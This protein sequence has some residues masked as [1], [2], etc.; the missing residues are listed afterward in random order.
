MKTLFFSLLMIGSF[1]IIQAQDISGVW[2][3]ETDEETAV[4]DRSGNFLIHWAAKGLNAAGSYSFDG[5]TLNCSFSD[6]STQTYSISQLVGGQGFLMTDTESGQTWWYAYQGEAN[7]I[8]NA[9]TSHSA[10]M[11]LPEFS[12]SYYCAEEEEKIMLSASEY[13]ETTTPSQQSYGI[14]GIEGDQLVLAFANYGNLVKL[15]IVDFADGQYFTIQLA[16]EKGN[17]VQKTYRYQGSAPTYSKEQVQQVVQLYTNNSNQSFQM[18]M[19][20][21]NTMHNTSMSI[22]HAM[23]GYDT[24]YV[25]KDAY[26]NVIRRY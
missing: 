5:S 21:Q 8:S 14:W 11:S 13:F 9:A 23:G 25:V 6:G 17:Q 2:Y 15:P 18:Q 24:Q 16:D 1:S 12:G 20:M 10:G 19:Q 3:T 7:T 26:G 22:I 4:F